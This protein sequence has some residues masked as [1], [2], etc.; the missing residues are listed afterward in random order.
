MMY[1]K[2][3]W[4]NNEAQDSALL[5]CS[6]VLWRPLP[7]AF[8]SAFH[9]QDSK[10]E[11]RNA[12]LSYV[13]NQQHWKWRHVVIFDS[14][15]VFFTLLCQLFSPIFPFCHDAISRFYPGLPFQCPLVLQIQACWSGPLGSGIENRVSIWTQGQIQHFQKWWLYACHGFHHSG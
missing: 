14:Y 15:Q 9:H 4:R 2:P 3:T 7:D 5:L 12:C 10:T 11:W 8:H 13:I 6:I 1:N